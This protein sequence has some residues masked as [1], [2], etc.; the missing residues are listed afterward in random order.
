MNMATFSLS[1]HIHT[2][3]SDSDSIYR[4]DARVEHVA[5]LDEKMTHCSSP[6]SF[7]SAI[8]TRARCPQLLYGLIQPLLPQR[9]ASGSG[10]YP[11]TTLG[12][13]V[14]DRGCASNPSPS[15]ANTGRIQSR[16]AAR[17]AA[18]PATFRLARRRR[19]ALCWRYRYARNRT[20]NAG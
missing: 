1:V 16:E 17:G 10:R 5:Q 14:P 20:Y 12:E 3:P 18:R 2:Y 6:L 11:V 4:T 15:R 19:F 8:A 13:G 9:G 7:D